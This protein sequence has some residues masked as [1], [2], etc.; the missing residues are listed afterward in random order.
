MSRTALAKINLAEAQSWWWLAALTVI[1]AAAVAL[2]FDP[3]RGLADTH[4]VID[5]D[6][7][8]H[9]HHLTALESFWR[10]D[11]ALW[12]YSPVFMA[13]YPSNTI[14]D[15]SIKL[16][17]LLAI[18]FSALAL[19]P[20]Q[21]FKVLAFLS[22]ALVPPC[23]FFTARNV[24]AGD[25]IKPA[26]ALA[27]A[28]MGT[29]YWWNSLPRE[30]F[31]YGMLGY[32]ASCYAS[33]LGISL[34][35]RVSKQPRPWSPA[36]LGWLV[37]AALLLPL[38]VQAVVVCIPPLLMLIIL[39]RPWQPNLIVWSAVAA[40]VALAINLPWLA[41]AFTHRGDDA[42]AMIVE[43]LPIFTTLDPLAL[44][45]DYFGPGAYWSFRV[46]V[47]EKVF[48]LVLLILGSWGTVALIRSEHRRFG[49]AAATT[50]ALLFALAYFG[51]FMSFFRGWQ[52][53][54]FK[55]AA[56]VFL[57]LPAA[58]IAAYVWA[59][60]SS[61]RHR[62]IAGTLAFLGFAGFV[63]NLVQTEA[64]GKMHLRTE[65]VPEIRAII[66]W[67][68]DETFPNSR[69]LFEESG[70][71]SG[72]VYNG[73]Y[74]SSFIAHWTGRQLIGGPIN[75]YN[76]RHHFAEFHSGKLF[77]R[78]IGQLSDDE[79]RNYFRLYN[80]GAVVAFHPA[81][82]KKLLAVPELV[83]LKQRIGPVHLMRVNRPS[84]WFIQGQGKIEAAPGRLRFSA[85]SGSDVT[86]K[87][88]WIAGLAGSPSVRIAPLKVGDDPI[89]FI[90]VIDPPAAFE[91][92]A[93]H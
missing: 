28:S 32:P 52:P 2:L 87:Y 66:D 21:W 58:Y 30:M 26:A 16:F 75:L 93:A 1:H 4:P 48:R 77:K 76:D 10:Q 29:V 9:F 55:V 57:I 20:I 41:P 14:Q 33:I 15:L 6:W 62:L 53:L 19:M 8:L 83:E 5:Q 71:E 17:E 81:S 90:R 25:N 56:D 80:I 43:Q 24:F 70:D 74:L 91:L 86:V 79:I 39:A 49:L 67:V 42:S 69:V 64:R 72:F 51:S 63:I 73:M 18:A 60:P 12:G 68:K 50:I 36:H 54:R 31:F 78:D 34:F 22:V 85:V 47:W 7:G 89:P 59:A 27:A 35:Y 44:L 40:V 84:G 38:H 92:R 61:S 46:G 37:F 82:I 45:R 3:L 13:G 65:L 11:K 88:H 23:M